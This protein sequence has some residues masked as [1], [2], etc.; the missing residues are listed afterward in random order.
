MSML[1]I[2]K[3]TLD[4]IQDN[5]RTGWQHLGIP[6]GGYMDPISAKLANLLVGNSPQ[7][8]VLEIFLPGPILQFTSNALIAITGAGSVVS[9]DGIEIEF[10]RPTVV[11]AGTN[12]TWQPTSI[13]RI[14][15]LAIRGGW[16]LTPWLGSYSTCWCVAESG[17]QGRALQKNDAIP[18]RE[19]LKLPFV[20]ARASIRPLPWKHE[21]P[22]DT[23]E[24][25][26]LMPDSQLSLLS[27]ESMLHL[28]ST[29]FLL[30]PN[31]NRMS[32]SLTGRLLTGQ[33]KEMISSAVMLGSL[34]WLPEGQLQIFMADHPTTGGYPRIAQVAAA[35]RGRLAQWSLQ[36][37]IFFDWITREKAEKSLLE[38][39]AYLTRLE[40][41]LHLRMVSYLTGSS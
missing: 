12:L 37:P 16:Q 36:K 38:Q 18:F 31:S 17:W 1:V 39:H 2:K 27:Q 34:Q 4:T 8:A 14:S 10:N 19:S 6:V 25:I 32:Y 21:V 35:D 26:R 13:G 28:T 41:A 29:P 7:E 40:K 23:N 22:P 9:S 33:H 30:H 11:G 3:G 15:Y 20:P 24:P 5:G